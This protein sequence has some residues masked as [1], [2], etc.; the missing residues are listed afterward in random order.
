[1]V[2]K[3]L[4]L[5]VAAALLAG[6][7]PPASAADSS[8]SDEHD[9]SYVWKVKCNCYWNFTLTFYHGDYNYEDYCTPHHPIYKPIYE[10]NYDEATHHGSSNG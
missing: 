6:F 8:S 2:R 10:P 3:M 5:V 1:M 9:Y 4:L 7:T